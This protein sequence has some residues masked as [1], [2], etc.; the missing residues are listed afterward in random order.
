MMA[1]AGPG[2]REAQEW[3]GDAAGT[4]G[5][6]GLVAVTRRNDDVVADLDV[7]DLLQAIG[8]GE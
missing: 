4:D 6:T 5:D 2:Q 8:G 7:L 1:V 3:E